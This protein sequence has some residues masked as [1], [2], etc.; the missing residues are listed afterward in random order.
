MW[1]ERRRKEKSGHSVGLKLF[2]FV[3]SVQHEEWVGKSASLSIYRVQSIRR[4]G[5]MQETTNISP[6]LSS[7]HKYL[8][9]PSKHS[10][11]ALP[12]RRHVLKR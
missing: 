8:L 12:Q 10:S 2:L 5:D 6:S 4:G 7:F 9:S 3:S 11:K 1:F